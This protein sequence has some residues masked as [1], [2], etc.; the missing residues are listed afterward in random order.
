MLER[1]TREDLGHLSAG[2]RAERVRVRSEGDSNPSTAQTAQFGAAQ[3]RSYAARSASVGALIAINKQWVLTANLATTRRAPTSYE[4]YANGVHAATAVYEQ[5]DAAQRLERGRN[6][7]IGLAW[8]S[9][10]HDLK[11]SAF[12]SRFANYIL[13]AATGTDHVDDEGNRLP[14]FNFRGVRARL[15]GMEAQASWRLSK[16]ATRTHLNAVIDW[17]RGINQDT[18]EALPRLAPLRATVGLDISQGAWAARLEAQHAAD[19]RRVPSPDTATA[20]WTLVNLSARYNLPV[21]QR[22]AVLFAKLQNA[23][24]KL[25]YSASATNTIRPL[26]PLPARALT[27]GLSVV[28]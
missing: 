23:G 20:G 21:G 25:A 5:G 2:L 13:L 6:I 8:Q 10:E 11:V 28:F 18:G 4:L 15:Y 19:Q 26:A 24:N 7:D 16:G 12:D 3:E 14:I 1:W 27:A 9:G 22:D 17:V